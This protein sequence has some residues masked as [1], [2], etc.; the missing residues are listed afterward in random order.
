MSGEERGTEIEREGRK[1]SRGS[2]EGDGDG[3]LWLAEREL[4]DKGIPRCSFALTV[5]WSDMA[6]SLAL[7]EF[8]CDV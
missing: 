6:V 2:A 1:E 5:I 3:C 7:F 8:S 4:F